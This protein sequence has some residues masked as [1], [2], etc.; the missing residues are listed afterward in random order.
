LLL[1][2]FFIFIV[3]GLHLIVIYQTVL[4]WIINLVAVRLWVVRSM[5]VNHQYLT[6]HPPADCC[7]R[8]GSP[9]KMVDRVGVGTQSHRV[10]TRSCRIGSGPPIWQRCHWL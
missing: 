5:R 1:L 10:M 4:A 3:G 7:W 8:V 2:F 6:K 9:V